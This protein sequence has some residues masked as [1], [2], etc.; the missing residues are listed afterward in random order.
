M[1]MNNQDFLLD[2]DHT[3]GFKVL[4][5]DTTDGFSKIV[6]NRS[7]MKNDD[8]IMS[9]LPA[10]MFDDLAN[11]SARKNDDSIMSSLPAAM[12]DAEVSVLM[13]TNA[14]SFTRFAMCHHNTCQVRKLGCRENWR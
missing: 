6:A 8:N 9:S 2:S 4:D 13:N 11:R 3:D 10:A 1:H 7:A 14:A 12:F 5:S